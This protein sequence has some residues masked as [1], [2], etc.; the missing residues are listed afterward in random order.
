VELKDAPE[1]TYAATFEL[2][3]SYYNAVRTLRPDPDGTVRLSLHSYGD[4]PLKVRVRTTEG[5][6]PLTATLSDALQSSLRA[7]PPSPEV[8]EA[9]S[10]IAAH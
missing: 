7:E 10:Y 6:V 4:Y 2:D 8:A 5:E 9:L 1:G 3:P